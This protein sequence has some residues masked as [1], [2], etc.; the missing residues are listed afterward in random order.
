MAFD[1]S[2]LLALVTS[3]QILALVSPLLT[4]VVDKL[5]VVL[6]NPIKPLVAVVIGALASALGGSGAA[7]GAA[8]GVAGIGVAE[9]CTHAKAVVVGPKK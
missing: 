5:V 7:A 4:E 8:A 2:S 9:I 6:P 3:P 1:W